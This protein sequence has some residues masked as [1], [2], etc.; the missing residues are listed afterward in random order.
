MN[1]QDIDHRWQALNLHIG[2]I[3]AR[4]AVA[5]AVDERELRHEIANLIHT[6]SGLLELSQRLRQRRPAAHA[7]ASGDAPR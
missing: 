2:D 1:T 7:D 3:R 4:V 5:G 6:A